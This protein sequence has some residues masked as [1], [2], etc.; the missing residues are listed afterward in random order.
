MLP[1][2]RSGTVFDWRNLARSRMLC[3]LSMLNPKKLP[4]FWTLVVTPAGMTAHAELMARMAEVMAHPE[5]YPLPA[6]VGPTREALLGALA[7]PE[8]ALHA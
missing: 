5:D 8:D 7:A 3:R 2:G 4:K 6:P 1:G